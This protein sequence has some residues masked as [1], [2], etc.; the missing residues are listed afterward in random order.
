MIFAADVLSAVTDEECRALAALS[1]GKV[2]L[3]VGAYL[4]R[5]TIALASTAQIVHSVD[6]HNGGPP[7]E[8]DTLPAFLKNLSRYGVRE[9]VIVHVGGSLQILPIFRAIF[10]VLFI[11]AAHQQE[12]VEQDIRVG[13]P[14]LRENGCIAFHDYGAS[15][16]WDGRQWAPFG[17]TE[18][19]DDLASRTG[20]EMEVAGSLAIVRL[21][22]GRVV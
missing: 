18:A 2:V 15:G 3:E 14:C 9:K 1:A 21:H 4:G 8:E 5:S 12:W 13:M 6:P 17:V 7:G 16:A 20:A 19:V 11:D 10:D 22:G